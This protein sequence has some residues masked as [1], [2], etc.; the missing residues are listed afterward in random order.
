[1]NK[2][3]KILSIALLSLLLAA[4]ASAQIITY[5]G[6]RVS[7]TQMRTLLTRVSRQTATFRNEVMSAS[8]RNILNA[9]REDRIDNLIDEFALAATTLNNRFGERR[10]VTVEVTNVLERAAQ[11]DRFMQRNN[12]SYRAESQ[13]TALRT[14]L[15]RLAQYNNV[16]WNWST[17]GTTYPP[18][19]GGRF[20]NRLTGTYRIDYGRSDNVGNVIDRAIN[21]YSTTQRPNLRRN[22]ER[23]LTSPEMLAIDMSGTRVT[24]ASSLAPQA[25]FDADGVPRSETNARGRTM[26]TTAR[27]D[28]NGMSIQYQGERANDFN[29]TFATMPNGDL[30]VTR[31]VYV[32]NQN[33]TVSVTSVYDK[34]DNVARWSDVNVINNNT[35]GN[36]PN[37][38]DTGNFLI[39][40]GT[41][42]TAR[43]NDNLTTRA[44]QSGDRFTMTVTSPY[45]YNGAVIEGH[46]ESAASSGRLA[47]RA[48]VTLV[49]D[50]IRTLDGRNY[51][52]AGLVD[53]VRAVNGE[54]VSITNEG[55][56]RDTNQTTRTV[57]RAG[58]GAVL[59]AIIGA[60]AGGGEGAAIG[61]AVG[62]GAGAGSV[63]LQGRDNIELAP[64]T[65]F[66]ITASAPSSVGVVR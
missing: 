33:R 13:W 66:M 60:V 14:D 8:N 56:V 59:G 16:S 24:M 41:R 6:G 20:N 10:D 48:N 64:G 50:S 11:I 22:L 18:S 63:L 44:S 17:G 61:A 7:D 52:F 58:I 3:M 53:S 12:L 37:R 19:T 2:Q 49:F 5:R 36:Y 4:A 45:Q 21:S 51:R 30:R 39:S 47:G 26:T 46:V 23:R 38:S 28:R 54:T 40:N 43:L 27:A 55:T 34:I 9:N 1:M 62:A 29:V 25:T 35:A 15:D 42:L 32:E 57:T 65:E 31:T